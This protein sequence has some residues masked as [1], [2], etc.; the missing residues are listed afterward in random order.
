VPKFVVQTAK[1]ASGSKM[2]WRGTLQSSSAMRMRKS[3]NVIVKSAPDR[4]AIKASRAIKRLTHH[5]RGR[6]VL[7]D[8]DCS[9][10]S[11]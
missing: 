1:G 9:D 10:T 4:H 5:A 6:D 7:A 8:I 11:R 2:N 3:T